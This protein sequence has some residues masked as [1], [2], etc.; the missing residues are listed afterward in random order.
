[1]RSSSGSS[2]S[3]SSQRSSDNSAV[4]RPSSANR[5]ASRSIRARTP[6]FWAKRRSSG[7]GALTDTED[8]HFHRLAAGR[9]AHGAQLHQPLQ[10]RLEGPH[11]ESG[12]RGELLEGALPVREPNHGG[13]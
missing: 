8:L 5:L 3:F 7:V 11:R 13:Y 4:P 12:A 6:N 9:E 2:V 1:M 10:R